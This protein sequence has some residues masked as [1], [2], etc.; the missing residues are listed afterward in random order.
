MTTRKLKIKRTLPSPEVWVESGVKEQATLELGMLKWNPLQ[1][2]ERTKPP[3]IAGLLEH[4]AD[5]GR[6]DRLLVV[7]SR[8]FPG[9]YWIVDGHRRLR[10]AEYFGLTELEC[11]VLTI[12]AHE[13]EDVFVEIEFIRANGGKRQHVAKNYF[14]MWARANGHG[15]RL[16]SR[17]PHKVQEQIARLV[18]LLGVDETVRLGLDGTQAPNIV[19]QVDSILKDIN[20]YDS[21]RYLKPET[22]LKW[23]ISQGQQNRVK[24]YMAHSAK[25]HKRALMLYGCI[26]NDKPIPTKEWEA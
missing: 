22:V 3:A 6:I 20:N 10:C 19:N 23:L 4:I 21:I 17:M 18:D 12:P 2:P 16:L 9:F 8:K 1:D 25:S 13:K 15:G 24:E 14:G 11:D 26:T 5:S 7:R